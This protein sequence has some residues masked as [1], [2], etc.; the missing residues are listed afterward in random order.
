MLFLFFHDVARGEGLD[1]GSDFLFG[2]DETVIHPEIDDGIDAAEAKTGRVNDVAV[3]S[4]AAAP[5]QGDRSKKGGEIVLLPEDRPVL[6]IGTVPVRVSFD[7]FEERGEVGP[8]DD[9]R[10]FFILGEGLE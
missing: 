3:E 10:G 2:I 4:R 1:E 6:L 7:E 9:F 5:R 8:V